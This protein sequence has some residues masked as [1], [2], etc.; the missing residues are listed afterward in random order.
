MAALTQR[1]P[2][3][4]WLVLRLLITIALYVLL[5]LTLDLTRLVHQVRSVDGFWL[6]LSVLIP[7]GGMLLSAFK[8]GVVLAILQVRRPYREL[9][10][11]YWSSTFYNNV[12]PGSIGGDV[13]R[14]GGLARSGVSLATS[15][16]SVLAD[17]ATG[18]WAGML[19]GLLCS[20]LLSG[21]PYRWTLG[22]LFGAIVLG[23]VAA[24]WV[25]P[26]LARLLPARFKKCVVLAG[27]LRS[28]RQ[29]YV[30]GLSCLF[31][32]LVI[33]NTY[34]IARALGIE[35]SLLVY[36]VYAQAVVLLTLLP[37][38]INGIG[39][40]ETGMV[41]F[42]GSVGVPS[43]SAALVGVLLLAVNVI[44]SLPGGALGM[45]LPPP[46][47]AAAQQQLSAAELAAALPAEQQSDKEREQL[48]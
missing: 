36:G 29:W 9:L 6:L 8:W 10:L 42:L 47:V 37:I 20:L 44:V 24:V 5:L 19:L 27:L 18:L 48:A 1:L 7:L 43:E 41:F 22:A 31:Q 15:G 26:R 12:L 25:L 45:A 32:V 33:L 17:R 11:R 34:T 2:R 3:S 14:I 39:V 38:S 23:S 16:L 35:L 30:L 28:H 21:L 13:V 46:A 40:R 4:T